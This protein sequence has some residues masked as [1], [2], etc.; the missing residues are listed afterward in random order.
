MELVT[1]IEKSIEN[2]RFAQRTLYERY[3]DSL[4]T[5]VYRLT[6]D[7]ESASELLQDAFIDAFKGLANL[8]EPKY[9][10]AWIKKIL[11]RKTYRYLD[12]KKEITS[13]D[14]IPDTP[15]YDKNYLDAE[16][17]E[18]AIMKLPTK[19]RTV[20]IMAEVEGFS[21]KEIGKTL[22]ITE[23]T[24]RSQLNYAKTKLKT[25]LQPYIA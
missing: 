22:D 3:K 6:R 19:S 7:S 1:L 8:Q 4:Y 17:I 25:Y 5:I 18:K 2:D 24:S 20:F 12:R 14:Q 16:Y 10:H 23:G 15:H 9:F 11:I 13:I 21:H